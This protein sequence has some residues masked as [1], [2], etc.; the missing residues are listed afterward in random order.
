MR[1]SLTIWLFVAFRTIARDEGRGGAF[2]LA[3]LVGGRAR[4][5]VRIVPIEPNFLDASIAGA[6]R[7]LDEG[8]LPIVLEKWSNEPNLPWR[9]VIPSIGF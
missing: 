9:F 5:G 8:G 6:F 2:R 3:G 7:V 4:K 1:G